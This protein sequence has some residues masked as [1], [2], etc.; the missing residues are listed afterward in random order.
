MS[1]PTS[2]HT[3]DYVKESY[4]VYGKY[5]ELTIDEGYIDGYDPMSLN[6]PHSS[7]ER[8]STWVGMGMW[9]ASLAGVGFFIFGLALYVWPELL[10]SQD[11]NP[12]TIMLIGAIGFLVT[13]II[14]YFLIR[15]GRKEYKAYRE[16]TGRSN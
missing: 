2:D 11:H 7:L 13:A 14:G 15:S 5:K 16:R 3:A 12:V 10:G 6:A 9:L 4:P 8:G 1:T